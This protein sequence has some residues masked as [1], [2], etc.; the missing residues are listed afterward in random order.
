MS[1]DRTVGRN[2]FASLPLYKSIDD[3]EVISPFSVLSVELPSIEV[4]D[5]FLQHPLVVFFFKSNG[6]GS[7]TDA[8]ALFRLFEC[9][10]LQLS[11]FS[12]SYVFI[13]IIIAGVGDM[14]S[15]ISSQYYVILLVSCLYVISNL[16]TVLN[17]R[18]ICIFFSV[19]KVFFLL[20]SYEDWYLYLWPDNEQRKVIGC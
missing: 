16:S 3:F 2:G 9:F 4:F 6:A 14:I 17:A 10:F 13:N 8:V 5:Y 20:F 1:N 15:V 12:V 18:N 19:E 7:C 11:P